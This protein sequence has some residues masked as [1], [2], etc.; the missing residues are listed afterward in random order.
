MPF[1]RIA[2]TGKASFVALSFLSFCLA[3]PVSQAQAQPDDAI[4]EPRQAATRA[5]TSYD[6]E[7]AMVILPSGE[8]YWV[9]RD[10]HSILR[11]DPAGTN[12]TSTDKRRTPQGCLEDPFLLS[13]FS[14][15]HAYQEALRQT[16]PVETTDG[17]V[18]VKDGGFI[19][20]HAHTRDPRKILAE[21]SFYAQFSQKN[22][23]F[24][25]LKKLYSTTCVSKSEECAPQDYKCSAQQNQYLIQEYRSFSHKETIRGEN[26][27]IGCLGGPIGN[28]CYASHKIGPHTYIFASFKGM[29]GVDK[30]SEFSNRVVE[31]IYNQKE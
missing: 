28:T 31:N 14:A 11:Y 18:F 23:S 10:E 2:N 25:C 12:N 24:S 7:H 16:W 15:R 1:S 30:I 4:Q 13:A 8:S 29:V 9:R 20:Q 19:V 26:F 17:R 5:C 27:Y 6:P 22:S 3:L 21:A